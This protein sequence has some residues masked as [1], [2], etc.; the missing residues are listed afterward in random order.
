MIQ[1]FFAR[2]RG[3]YVHPFL[4]GGSHLHQIWGGH[5]GQ[6]IRAL[7]AFCVSF[8]VFIYCFISKPDCLK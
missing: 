5:I 1:H 3:N 4:T 2:F 7:N 6:F 8:I